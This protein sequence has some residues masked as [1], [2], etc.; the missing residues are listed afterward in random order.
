M[1]ALVLSWTVTSADPITRE[2]AQKKAEAFMAGQKKKS[3]RLDAVT[4]LRKLAPSRSG[5]THARTTDE[6]YIF[7]KGKGEGFVI[8]SGDDQTIPVLGYCDQG[9]FD[10]EQLPPQLQWLLDDYAR[11]IRAIQAGAPVN[12]VP[13][14]HSKVETFMSCK[15]NQTAPFNDLCP[16]DDRRHSVTGCVATAMAQILYYNREKSVTETTTTIPGYTTGTK[17]LSVPG[18]E[19]GAPI[20]W[21]NMKDTYGSATDL[22][23]KAVAELML[24]CGVAVRMDYTNSSSGAQ[25]YEVANACKN[26]FGYGS[27]VKYIDSFSSEDEFDKIVYN[28]LAAGR[29]VYL[30]GYTGDY[31]VGHAFLTCGYENQRYWINWGWGGQSDG[32]YYLSNLTPGDGQGTGGSADGYNL[33]RTCII[34]F[35]PENFGEKTMSFLD[36][37]VK[38]IC[39]EHWDTDSD[40]KLT[41]NEAAAVTSLGEAFQGQSAI[42]KFPELYYFTSLT[43]I[44][45][46]A[47]DGCALLT[48]IRLPKKLKKIGEGAFMNCQKLAQINLPTGVDEIGQ[49]AFEGCKLLASV[50]LPGNITEIKDYAFRNCAAITTVNLPINVRLIGTEAYSGCTKLSSFTVNTYRPAE[51]ELLGNV[52][53]GIDLSK[54]ELHVK[55]GTKGYYETASQW[56]AFGNVIQTRDISGGKF[57]KMEVGNTYFLYN[58]GTGQ[59]LTKGEAYGTQAVVGAEP[60]RFKVVHPSSKPENVFYLSSPDTGVEGKYLFRT[61]GDGNVGQ[62]VK[63]TFVDGTALAETAYWTISEVEDN[64]YNIQ[65]PNPADD[66]EQHQFLGIQTDHQSNAASPTYGAYWDVDDTNPYN[67]MWQFVLY[68]EASAQN[69]A[70]A[71]ALGKLI[72]TAKKRNVSYADEQA[73]Y[74]NMEST[75]EELKAAESSLRRKLK[76]IDFYHQEVRE[77]CV[78]Y[79]DADDDGELSYKEAA[80]V[81]DFGWLFYFLRNTSLVH[82]D[83][84]Q[85]FTNARYIHGNFM[86]GCTNLET[87]VLPQGLEKIYYYAFKGCQK[88]EAIEIP[89]FVNQ[90]GEDAFEGCSALRTVTVG[91]S[92]PSFI[93]LGNNVFRNVPLEE[94]T[95]KVPFG[96]KA[97]Y[98]QA[99]VWKDFGRIVEVRGHAQPKYSPVETDVAGYVMNVATRK[100]I[101]LGEAY[102]TQSV[103]ARSGKLYQFRHSKTMADSVYYLYSSQTGTDGNILFRTNTDTRVGAGVKACFGDG[104]L[105]EKAYWKLTAYDDNT[106]TLHV[107]EK[108][109]SFVEGEYLGV[110]EEHTTNATSGDL[111]FGL[112]WDVKGP[113][114]RWAFVRAED[115]D[116]AKALDDVADQLADLLKRASARGLDVST[117]QAVYDNPAS[118]VGEFQDAVEALRSKLHYITF[119]DAKAQTLCVER[120][121]ADGDGELSEEEAASVTDIGEIF[122]ANTMKSFEELRYFTGLT[123]LPENAFRGALSLQSICLP[124]CI[125]AIGEY[126]FTNCASLE[127]IVIL[128][129]AAVIPMG[130]IGINSGTNLYV[131]AK[132]VEAYTADDNWGSRCIVKEYTGKPVV[133]ATATRLYGRQAAPSIIKVHIEGAPVL[134]QPV[135]SCD[136]ITVGTT[137]VGKYPIKIEPGTVTTRGVEFREGVFT[138]EPSVLTVTAKSYT[139]NV[140]E[141]NPEF[142]VTIKG[143]RN[144]ETDTVLTV[145]P[146]VTCEATADSPA[147]EY[148]IIVSGAEAANYTFNYVPGKLTV[149]NATGI[150]EVRG[151]QQKD[152]EIFDLQ[153]RRVTRPQRGMFIIKNSK[154]SKIIKLKN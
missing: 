80:D 33:G 107:P 121:D 83:E 99:L 154:N 75:I 87:V 71:Q 51:L 14:N 116:A 140:G 9:E 37:N 113:G 57:T 134:G 82:V 115:M 21:A 72:A 76:F 6:Y 114:A 93:R 139:R 53:S 145:K 74:D 30:G 79:F 127:N 78:T 56:E 102:G 122:R 1:V 95:L 124:A 40:G 150:E 94:C 108:D 39:L 52:F 125:T 137:P 64:I 7:N 3:I 89:E 130:V 60:M 111:T 96:T 138:V 148:D 26:Y 36:A 25:I 38:N 128:N 129:E 123:E 66:A 61:S 149:V 86:Q 2:Q 10:Y 151:G 29:P 23:K 47:F 91:A 131:P 44:D 84:L 34:G 45:P 59:Y 68:D 42:K 100:F 92:D 109:A 58:L 112:Y 32:Y 48:D 11:Q 153:G 27:S 18:I 67:C 54:A 85:Y 135:C 4:N 77:K 146:I 105:S 142:E 144:R 19:A 12:R 117:E 65:K 132:M 70:E 13:A 110:D 141:P 152:G 62:G 15:W 136:Y 106:F 90:I 31:S 50:D 120:W 133:T 35:E 28:E 63:A 55:Q 49:A 98:E 103:V 97:L 104:S 118:T 41:Y 88:L 24:Y 81:T 8:M 17:G 43:Q 69:F 20:D 22:Q 5:G 101:T 73:V 119:A 126:A 16:L 46:H 147:G 143:Y